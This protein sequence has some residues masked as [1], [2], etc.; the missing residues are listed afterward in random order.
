MSSATP[1]ATL[2]ATIAAER[3]RSIRQY[4]EETVSRDLLGELLRVAGRAPSAFNLQPWRL[5]VV[6]D[7]ELRARLCEAAFGQPQVKS[8]PAV[9]V[10][11][12]DMKDTFERIDEVLPAG[13]EGPERQ[14]RARRILGSFEGLSGESLEDWGARQGNIFLG[15]L[16]LLAESLGL[17]TSPMLGFEPDRVRALLDI[18]AHRPVLALVALGWPGQE[19]AISGRHAVETV[20][21]FL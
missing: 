16:L 19:G 5:V 14:E 17:A 20:A 1:L 13:L 21:R 11:T 9:L 10:L 12:T 18:P 7:A 6:E 8:A 15:Y 2:T 4:R 3:R